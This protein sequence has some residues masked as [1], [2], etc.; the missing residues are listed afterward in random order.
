MVWISIHAPMKG[1]TQVLDQE[2]DDAQISIHAPM[3]GATLCRRG[4]ADGHPYFNPRTH[5]GC[6]VPIVG[7][8]VLSFRIS[9]HAPMKGATERGLGYTDKGF[10]SIHAPMKGA[11]TPHA[12]D[13]YDDWISIH[14]PMKGA[15]R[16]RNPY[17]RPF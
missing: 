1:A 6:D 13:L 7:L 11:T 17:R 15:T 2:L 9:I 16:H 12:K 3:K 14:A 5:E 10:I 4:R 8:D